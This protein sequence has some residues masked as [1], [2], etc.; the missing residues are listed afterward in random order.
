MLKLPRVKSELLAGI[1]AD[2]EDCLEEWFTKLVNE[3]LQ[4][5]F[6]VDALGAPGEIC[7]AAFVHALLDSQ[8]EADQMTED[9][10]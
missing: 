2:R 6:A 7:V 8:A 10:Q 5:V 9:F 3:N 1:A 4:I